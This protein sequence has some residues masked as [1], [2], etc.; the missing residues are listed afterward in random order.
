LIA[1]GQYNQQA[2][3]LEEIVVLIIN[4]VSPTRKRRLAQSWGLAR[5][6]PGLLAG[7]VFAAVCQATPLSKQV[8]VKD[9]APASSAAGSDS[10]TKTGDHGKVPA[11]MLDTMKDM[12]DHE[13]RMLGG[14]PVTVAREIGRGKLKSC[15]TDCYVMLYMLSGVPIPRSQNSTQYMAVYTY[16]IGK[17]LLLGTAQV[18]GK[19]LR[20][21]HIKSIGPDNIILNTETF[22]PKDKPTTPSGKGQATYVVAGQHVIEMP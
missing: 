12:V 2:W 13:A 16:N 1:L 15:L 20:Y 3:V 11:E 17:P 14:Q 18:G 6:A 19:G 10:K 21:C 5:L 4:L 7:F 22:L 9:P 8:P